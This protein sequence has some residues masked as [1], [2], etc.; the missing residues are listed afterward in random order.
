MEELKK[1]WLDGK[2][3][4]WP[5]AKIHL[6]THT[7]HYGGG[8][9]EGMRA[10]STSKGAAVFRL[11]EHIDR[12]F[13]SASC[14]EMKLPFSKEEIAKAV[15]ELININDVKE[16]YIRPIAYFGYGKMGLNPVGAPLNVAIAV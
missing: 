13:Y 14:L 11:K 6:L 2:L 1:I 12:F 5:D 4:D 15:L 16:C 3:V 9:F 7:L 8:V 10:Y